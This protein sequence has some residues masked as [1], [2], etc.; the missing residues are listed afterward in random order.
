M[1]ESINRQQS[2]SLK[3]PATTKTII[4]TLARSDCLVQRP[5]KGKHWVCAFFD[6]WTIK[7]TENNSTETFRLVFQ[8]ESNTLCARKFKNLKKDL[9][10]QIE[11]KIHKKQ[12]GRMP[13]GELIGPLKVV[14]LP[15]A[16]WQLQQRSAEAKSV[17]DPMFGTLKPTG[18][19][20][21]NF[22]GKVNL[23]GKR[24]ECHLSIETSQEDP[25]APDL[26][27]HHKQYQTLL[28]DYSKLLSKAVA[29]MY[30]LW[31]TTW[32]V[33]E[34]NVTKS[35]FAQAMKPMSVRISEDTYTI[36]FSIPPYFFYGHGIEFTKLDRNVYVNLV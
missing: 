19:G 14:S 7:G 11:V 2:Y 31:D 22:K 36:Y 5:I 1:I 23:L 30:P 16:L 21:G 34:K 15:R 6:I 10:Y 4:A 26:S 24:I 8:S 17:K 18:R 13:G 33:D 35:A 29:E 9:G 3:V 20:I 27:V 28:K 25:F 32:R 12:N